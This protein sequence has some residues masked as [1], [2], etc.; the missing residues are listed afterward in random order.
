[1]ALSGSADGVL[2]SS[3]D[4]RAGALPALSSSRLPRRLRACT[5]AAPAAAR[6]RRRGGAASGCAGRASAG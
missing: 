5:T 6:R 2:S 4:G 1:L 3:A